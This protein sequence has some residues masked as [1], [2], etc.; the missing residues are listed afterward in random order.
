MIWFLINEAIADAS[1]D[2]NLSASDSCQAQRAALPAHA[3][4]EQI[5]I[6]QIKRNLP[7][8]HCEQSLSFIQTLGLDESLLEKAS[9]NFA[10][11]RSFAVPKPRR[12]SP[13]NSSNRRL[14]LPRFVSKT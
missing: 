6:D 4:T 12:I 14:V 2:W 9:L 5:I 8:C 13:T 1:S 7:R 11:S 3:R 10:C